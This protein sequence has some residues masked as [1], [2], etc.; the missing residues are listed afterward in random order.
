MDFFV[1]YVLPIF[2]SVATAGAIALAKY[3]HSQI[4]NYKKMIED[5]KDNQISEAVDA[6]L[7]PIWEELEELRTYVLNTELKE[8]KHID[9]VVASWRFR[10]IQLSKEILKQG[11]ITQKQYDQLTEFYK[12]YTE[13]GGNGQ[14]KA[15]YDKVMLLQIREA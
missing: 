13:L 2:L 6:K 15:Y 12:L 10:L 11:Y 1:K 14:A 5:K 7:E 8:K 9:V 3:F 4:K